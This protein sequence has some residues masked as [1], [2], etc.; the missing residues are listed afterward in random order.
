[1]SQDAALTCGALRG[2]GQIVYN[3]SAVLILVL[4]M[5]IS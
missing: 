1:M 5:Y 2:I 4:A 3:G